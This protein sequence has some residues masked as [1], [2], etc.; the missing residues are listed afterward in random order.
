MLVNPTV[1]NI[2]VIPSVASININ[3]TTNQP[4]QPFH[5]DLQ[6]R[7][8]HQIQTAREL[9][10][11]IATHKVRD[12]NDVHNAQLVNDMKTDNDLYEFW[13]NDCF[14]HDKSEIYGQSNSLPSNFH[15]SFFQF[16]SSKRIHPSNC[17]ILC[18]F[19][20]TLTTPT[21]IDTGSSFN[22]IN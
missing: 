17:K 22:S 16:T 4:P 20:K 18:T 7:I 13:R 2:A 12:D 10:Q 9:N 5:R 11:L 3:P 1:I 6:F 14:M 15:Q 21:V 8:Q 19:N